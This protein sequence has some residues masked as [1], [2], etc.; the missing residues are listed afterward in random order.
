VVKVKPNGKVK[1]DVSGTTWR[2]PATML[3][4]AGK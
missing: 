3:S 4:K 1:I 2:V